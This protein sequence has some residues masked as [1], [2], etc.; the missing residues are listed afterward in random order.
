MLLQQDGTNIFINNEKFI[1]KTNIMQIINYICYYHLFSYGGYKAAILKTFNKKQLI[2]I[3]LSEKLILIPTER[4]RNYENIWF[5]YK[6]V[7]SISKVDNKTIIEFFSGNQII[8][9]TSLNSL[10]KSIKLIEHIKKHKL[11]IY[12]NY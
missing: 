8:I 2:P 1:S 11:K 5:N 3:Y 9:K 12:G 6:E 4:I 7:K 10:K